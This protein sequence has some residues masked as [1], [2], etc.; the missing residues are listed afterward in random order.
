MKSISERNENCYQAVFK[1]YLPVHYKN[2]GSP[3]PVFTN[4]TCHPSQI[5]CLSH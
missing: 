5:R 3:A 2:Q 1:K 4:V